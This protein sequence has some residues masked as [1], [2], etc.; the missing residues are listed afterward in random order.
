VKE[1]LHIQTTSPSLNRRRFETFS[2]AFV[3]VAPVSCNSLSTKRCAHFTAPFTV[4]LSLDVL[5]DWILVRALDL[6]AGVGC[7]SGVADIL[8]AVQTVLQ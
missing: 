2:Y 5:G 3:I 7:I 4:S 1:R 6:A 8:G